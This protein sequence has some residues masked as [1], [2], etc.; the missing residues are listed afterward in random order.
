MTLQPPARQFGYRCALRPVWCALQS[1]FWNAGTFTCLRSPAS[2]CC[3]LTP[4]PPAHGVSVWAATPCR[5]ALLR[6][7]R[8]SDEKNRKNEN[9]PHRLTDA[10]EI[11]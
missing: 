9:P 3:N 11:W 6:W 8:R 1:P 5:C 10:D 2:L 4:P 7:R